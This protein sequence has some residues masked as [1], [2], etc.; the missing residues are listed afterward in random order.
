MLAASVPLLRFDDFKKDP[1]GSLMS[2]LEK[3]SS[4]APRLASAKREGPVRGSGSI[5]CYLR[6]PYGEGWALVGDAAMALDP[7]S[8]QGI[9]QASTHA[10]F[11][12]TRIGEFLDGQS[13]WDTTMKSYQQEGNDFSRKAYR[14]TST[15]SRDLRPMT[16][17]AL[18]KRGLS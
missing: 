3:M 6:I 15:F 10:V 8:G 12:A 13:N 18:A 2:E 11:L 14:N 17:A 9:D 16:R 1:E 5:P 4:L 7:W